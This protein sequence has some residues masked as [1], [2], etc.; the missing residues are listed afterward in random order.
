MTLYGRAAP[1]P[2]CGSIDAFAA[3]V[4]VDVD[5]KIGHFV[6][7]SRCGAC[8]PFGGTSLDAQTRW[9]TRTDSRTLPEPPIQQ[10]FADLRAQINAD[11]ALMLGGA[12]ST[13]DLLYLDVDGVLIGIYDNALQ[14]RPGV[15]G[16]VRW[17]MQHWDVCWLTTWP[18]KRLQTLLTVAGGRDIAERTRYI[19]WSYESDHTNKAR[20]AIQ[21]ANGRRF[22][23]LEDG[24]LEEELALLRQHQL[25]ESYIWINHL[26]MDGFALGLWR[27]AQRYGFVLIRPPRDEE[28]DR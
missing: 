7:C 10:Q 18:H 24:L 27:L 28:N 3:S 2:F 11:P 16:Q 23:W 15:I 21:Y 12:P 6:H 4:P 19:S 5:L 1:C 13:G 25:E 9:A 8:G 20:A 26:G 22:T 17:A 14:L